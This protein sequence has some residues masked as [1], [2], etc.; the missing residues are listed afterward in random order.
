MCILWDIATGQQITTLKD[1]LGEVDCLSI[2]PDNNTFLSGNSPLYSFYISLCLESTSLPPV[3]VYLDNL[4][5]CHK[6]NNSSP[7]Y[8]K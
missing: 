7:E 3:V 8:L 2:L 5:L 4:L 6:V 1:H